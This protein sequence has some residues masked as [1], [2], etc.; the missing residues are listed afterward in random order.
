MN[1]NNT[2]LG[3]EVIISDCSGKIIIE[4]IAS[5]I[6]EKVSLKNLNSGFYFL[7]IIRSGN[8]INRTFVIK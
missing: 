7:S 4:P 1:L 3:D 2:M 5:S 6:N 8:Q